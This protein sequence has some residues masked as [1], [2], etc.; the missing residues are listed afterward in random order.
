MDGRPTL[1]DAL[2]LAAESHRG[3][4]DKAGQPYI[5]HPIR[6]MLRVNT[7]EERIAALLHDVVEDTAVSPD[8]I[9]AAMGG[10][11]IRVLREGLKPA[12]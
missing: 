11:A 2:I 4:V 10:N 12:A 1:E 6:V 3:Q 5:L 8:E 9:R 7:L